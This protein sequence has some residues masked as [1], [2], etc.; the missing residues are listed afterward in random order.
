[1]LFFVIMIL[2]VI[3]S[4]LTFYIPSYGHYELDPKDNDYQSDLESMFA[5]GRIFVK[6]RLVLFP[7]L[8][9]GLWMILAVF[10]IVLL[11]GDSTATGG[12]FDIAGGLLFGLL[13]VAYVIITII[14]AISLWAV[15]VR[16]IAQGL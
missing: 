4:I 12:S 9:A 11:P 5:V 8:A 16:A 7:G 1:M 2:A 14:A 6:I 13:G 3:F 10:S 15:H